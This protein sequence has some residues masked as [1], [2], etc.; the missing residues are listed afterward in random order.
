MADRGDRPLP[1]IANLESQSSP[2]YTYYLGRIG[3]VMFGIGN[4]EKPW[5]D[6]HIIADLMAIR[7]LDM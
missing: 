3:R 4:H 5:G 2:N 7:C 1:I 6:G